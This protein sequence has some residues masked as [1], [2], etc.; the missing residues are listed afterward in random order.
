MTSPTIINV[1]SSTPNGFYNAGDEIWIQVQF[2]G[3]VFVNDGTPEIFLNV[4]GPG[5]LYA[6]GSG[7]DTLVFRYMPQPG[8][9]TSDLDYLNVNSFYLSNGT[10]SDGLGNDAVLTLP[11]PGGP[12]SLG[13][14]KNLRIDT[15]PPKVDFVT[16]FSPDGV[17]RDGQGIY[18][19]VHV[20]E[21]LS[22]RAWPS[23]WLDT[24]ATKREAPVDY[25]LIDPFD[26]SVVLVFLYIV[27]PGDESLDLDYL[28]SDAL[29]VPTPDAITDAVGNALV[30]TL[31]APAAPGSLGANKNIVID[32]AH[33]S[34]TGVTAI[35]PNG[36]YK[37]GD[38]ISLQV[39]FNEA[40][41]VTGSPFIVLET[42]AS[43]RAATYVGGSGTTALT[44]DYTVQVGDSS[45]DLDYVG[46]GALNA[47]GSIVNSLGLQAVL[48]LREPGFAG[49]LGASHAIVIDTVA[50]TVTGVG[51]SSADRI[52]RAGE[53]I[54]LW[55][56]FSEPVTVTGV[57]QLSLETG[58][59][60]RVATYLEGGGTSRLVF[61]YTVQAG[62]QSADLDYTG[63][64][65]L[66]PNGGSI[67]DLAGNDATLTLPAPGGAGSL[68]ANKA[69][70][71]DG[72]SP[73]LLS[74]VVEGQTV[75]LTYADTRALDGVNLP[76]VGAFAVA[77]NGEMVAVTGVTVNAEA[78]MVL[79]TLASR[80]SGGASV[81]LAY[82]DPTAGDDAN[83]I[84]DLAGNDAASSGVVTL[85][86]RSV[87]IVPPPDPPQPPGPQP[88]TPRGVTK[89]APP[90]GGEVR[91]TAY[92]DDLRGQGGND[93]F[94]PAGGNDLVNGGDGLDE[95][96]FTGPRRGY[97]V[98]HTQDGYLVRSLTDPNER[99][100]LV[101]VERL[102]FADLSINLEVGEAADRLA[103]SL[104]DSLVEL[105]I[106][107]VGRVPDADGM[108]YWIGRLIEGAS[109]AQVGEGFYAAAI[110]HSA[111]TGYSAG[112]S[113]A[114]FVDRVY[115]HVLGR[116]DPDAEGLAFWTAQLA[117]GT[118][119][120]GTLVSRMLES[121]HTFKGHTTYGYVADLLDNKIEVGR[122]FAIQMGLVHNRADD[123]ITEGMRMAQA[124]TPTDVDTAIGL[125]GVADGFTL[126]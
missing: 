86:N 64:A 26:G 37:P 57:P 58:A 112:M 102:K 35:T 124:V 80:V 120:R 8:Q 82:N 9:D 52:Y 70:V 13:F 28:D 79:L 43:D 60:D 5:A 3:P 68:G 46:I 10:V 99:V 48:T 31:P 11:P 126:Y 81:T 2:S 118:A 59:I 21:E 30:P 96:V 90:G 25:A 22:F 88:E 16:S 95:V 114:A 125:I 103:P 44:F 113:D 76:G 87:D 27:Q 107:Y 115:R 42:G 110:H 74:G 94:Y 78:R 23:L 63:L 1:T 56:D 105:Y 91:G 65:A 98:S 54:Y 119:T 97:A 24:G 69:L 41:T 101:N 61:R 75:V 77:Q 15:T 7:T 19:E 33:A 92:D 12:G 72:V 67:R 111:L 14:N 100:T 53:D 123:A 117:D 17:Y 45:A 122:A 89:T 47:G 106:G 71:V 38:V 93:G 108:A 66:A 40:V 55:V 51:A 62:D 84:Q 83:A 36:A 18:I 121:A 116:N 85:T 6:S 109:L 39:S 49:W 73:V 4:T 20:N 34:V 32:S 104:I 50:P 29:V